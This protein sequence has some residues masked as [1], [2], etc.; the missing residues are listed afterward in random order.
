MHETFS[1]NNFYTSNPTQ[2][3]IDKSVYN[4]VRR[5]FFHQEAKI[6]HYQG[7]PTSLEK[8]NKKLKN[9]AYINFRESVNIE[10]F[11]S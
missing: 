8:K 10:F 1:R 11:A 3:L 5:A 9:F 7:Q 2:T 6:T 4:P